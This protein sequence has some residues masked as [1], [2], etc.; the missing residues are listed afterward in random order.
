MIITK[1][2]S[3]MKTKLLKKVRKR[4]DIIHMPEGFT[5]G[6]SVYDY[7]LYRLVDSTNSFFERYAQLGHK[8]NS[9]LQYCDKSRIFETGEECINYLKGVIISRLR[10]E[11]YMSTKDIKRKSKHKKVWYL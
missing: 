11:G 6:D 2:V 3:N 10:S 7:N 4:F 8:P 5:Y 1:I 9:D